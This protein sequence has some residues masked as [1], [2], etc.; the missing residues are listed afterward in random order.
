MQIKNAKFLLS[1]ANSSQ[2]ILDKIPK[3]VFVG[4]S[5]VGKSSLINSL[6]GQK[7]LAI[8][9]RT[10]GR[11]KLVN[12]FGINDNSLHFVDLAGYGF[13]SAS[14]EAKMKWSKLNESFFEE[15]QYITLVI[16]IVDSRHLPTE[17]DKL[18][19]KFLF[20]KQIPYIIVATKIDKLPKTKIKPQ[21]L[22]IA[23]TFGLSVDNVFPYS[24]QTGYGKKE[25]LL[26]IEKYLNNTI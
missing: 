9:S 12:Y 19:Q 3:I 11:T 7:K 26:L 17:L 21:L 22:N 13:A 23:T 14:K 1:V 25:I 10:P 4:K 8:T 5:N 16:L 2:F 24:S 6:V 15:N 20:F 18:M